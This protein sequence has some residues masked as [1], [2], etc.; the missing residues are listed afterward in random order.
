MLPRTL[1][2]CIESLWRRYIRN[3][4]YFN[5]VSIWSEWPSEK[6]MGAR[7]GAR[8]ST[9]R[10]AS[11]QS[12]E[13]N[14]RANVAINPRN[15]NDLA[16]ACWN[17]HCNVN[18]WGN[19]QGIALLGVLVAMVGLWR[20]QESRDG[21]LFIIRLAITNY[22]IFNKSN[23]NLPAFV[24][25]AVCNQ[26]RCLLKEWGNDVS[27][28][29]PVFPRALSSQVRGKRRWIL[30]AGCQPLDA[31]R[32]RALVSACCCRV[33]HCATNYSNYHVYNIDPVVF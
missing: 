31:N 13:A 26:T 30:T 19:R 4:K 11:A 1:D 22:F 8:G 32:W 10:I 28:R 18:I 27:R 14:F 6:C 25:K 7:N 17:R 24:I 23:P 12:V 9:D 3:F 29:P 2:C 33:F 21:L 20:L 16:I 15:E 5:A